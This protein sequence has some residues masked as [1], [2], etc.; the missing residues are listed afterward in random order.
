MNKKIIITLLL[1][2][3]CT[4][5]LNGRTYRMSEY[6]I[7]PGSRNLSVKIA[8]AMEKIR[9]G[10][11]GEDSIVLEFL[12][13][14]YDF[15]AEDALSRH[16]F[17]SNHDQTESSAV[18]IAIEGWDGLTMDWS[19]SELVFHGVMIPV[20][21]TDSR[22]CTLKNFSIDFENPQI[23]QIRIVENR[24]DGGIVFRP[25]S[26]VRY[27]ISRDS[28]FETYGS[29]WNLHPTTGIAFEE[30]TRHILYNTGDIFYDT[31]G[32][33]ETEH[34]LLAPRWRDSRLESGT[35][36][37]MRTWKRP[38][39]GIFLYGNRNTHLYNI[40]VRYAFGMGLIAQLCDGI[41]LDGFG[42]CLKGEDDPRYFTT[43]AD[44]TH[45]SQCK[46]TITSVNG[47]Y[48]GMMDDAINIHGVYLRIIRIE[49]ERTVVG[50]FMHDQAWG[51]RWG[52]AG[53]SVQ[54]ILSGTM[55][56][57]GKPNRIADI[58]PVL[59]ENAPGPNWGGPASKA[60]G[61]SEDAAACGLEDSMHGV[62]EVRIV[63]ENP[64]GLDASAGELG[65]ENITWT[66]EV[67]FAGNTVRNNR[68]RGALFS[69]PKRTVVENNLFDH[70]SG[71]A[72]L[73]CGDCNGWFESGP[74]RD[75]LITG[76][77]FVNA[78]TS[79]YQFT[80]AVISIYP[81]I[82]DLEG[83]KQ[84]FHGGKPGAITVTGNTFE[85]F[86][87]PILYAK[88]VDGL[89]FKDNR[90]IRNHEYPPFHRIRTRFLLEKVHRAEIE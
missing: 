80:N 59:K 78:L 5:V 71:T 44:A 62:R 10:S 2:I 45:F 70:T 75:V 17:I 1:I 21:V 43:Q 36:V 30:D 86:D 18:G 90:I 38:A 7:R 74:C 24:G 84:Y 82:P 53:D 51:F 87:F 39:P 9:S 73:L 23:A 48:E 8:R 63:L 72:I 47:L 32:I 60:A 40:K 31:K 85:T 22:N 11:A 42:V 50:R 57:T 20:A 61:N 79:M 66:P 46:G 3:F 52:Y 67:Y 13:G 56:T 14:R 33:R 35:V 65:I 69:S 6:G 29:G 27:R 4:P 55:E 12:P 89:I 83:Q 58:V 19:G 15:H 41:T 64:H 68:A 25:E 16:Y 37:A 77:T 26:W 76:N 81:E 34:G 28:V 54:F 49:D 88:S